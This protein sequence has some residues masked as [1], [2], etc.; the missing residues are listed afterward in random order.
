MSIKEEVG[1]AAIDLAIEHGALEKLKLLF[2]KKHRILVL[3]SSGVGKTNLLESLTTL[4]PEIIDAVNRTEFAQ[5]AQVN[6]G[7]QPFVFIDTPGQE[8]HQS[9]RIQ[10][11]RE[12]MKE[13]LSG[14]INVVSYGYHEYDGGEKEAINQNGKISK[15]YLKRNR[16]LECELLKEWIPLV[17]NPDTGGWLITIITK[18][19]LWWDE[20]E[21]V[22]EHYVEGDYF[23]ALGEAKTMNP[24]VV[25]Y[26]SVFHRFYDKG[27]LSGMFDETDR[28]KARI[29][30]FSTLLGSTGIKEIAN[31][32]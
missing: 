27:N 14:I 28:K 32:K 18:A 11:I 29:N 4:T 12:A 20:R 26:S 5:K 23:A 30:L 3:G 7:T 24:I 13:G 21:Q 6:I 16:K 10:A 31:G 1:K 17:G 9:R 8:H 22:I 15:N 19:D 2:R 25:H